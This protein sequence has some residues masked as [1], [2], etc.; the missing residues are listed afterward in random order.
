MDKSIGEDIVLLGEVGLAGEVRSINRLE[1][2]LN[3]AATLGFKK[4]IV[5][6]ASVNDKVKKIKIDLH[7]VK[8]VKDAFQILF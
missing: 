8:F 3:E 4:A 7:P 2:R 6:S 1:Q 5:P